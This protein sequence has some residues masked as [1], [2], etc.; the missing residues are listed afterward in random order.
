MDRERELLCFQQDSAGYKGSS[1]T[2][3]GENQMA[4][5]AGRLFQEETS[6]Q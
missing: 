1:M 2:L 5:F 3:K 4:H 6:V